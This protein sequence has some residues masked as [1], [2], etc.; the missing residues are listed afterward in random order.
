[1]RTQLICGPFQGFIANL[2]APKLLFVNLND[3]L[4]SFETRGAVANYFLGVDGGGT[5]CRMRLTDAD[6]KIRAEAVIAKPS[7]LQLRDGAAAY[8]AITQLTKMVF[9]SA[10]LPLDATAQTSAC[11]GMSGAR[12]ISAREE[13][14][15]RKFPFAKVDVLDD[16]DIARAGAH[17]GDDGAVLIIGTG[18]GGLGIINGERHQIGGWGYH[19]GDQMSGAILGRELVRRASLAH[20]GIL[21]GSA[22]TKEVMRRF[23]NSLSRMMAWSF[24]NDAARKALE[25][26]LA[27]DQE[28]YTDVPARPADYGQFSPLVFEYAEREDPI[29]LE[30]LQFEVDAIAHYVNWFKNVGAKSIAIVGG[31]GTHL[32]PKLQKIHGDIIVAPKSEPLAGAVILAR[33]LSSVS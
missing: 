18:S 14:A 29:A 27:P 33:Q 10:G 12:L 13:F 22:L 28:L 3:I 15:A 16:I 11:F 31:L 9:E 21:T 7:N 20:E 30:L 8:E 6:Q 2:F 23:D 26:T 5:N 32:L 25:E 24:D 1:M 4:I 19:I 17:E